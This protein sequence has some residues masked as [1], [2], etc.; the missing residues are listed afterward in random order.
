MGYGQIGRGGL[1]LLGDWRREGGWNEMRGR[2]STLL[3]YFEIEISDILR[4]E[5]K[6]HP[7]KA[8]TMTD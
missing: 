5:R 7:R 2:L 1:V 3:K 6:A 4:K 8:R